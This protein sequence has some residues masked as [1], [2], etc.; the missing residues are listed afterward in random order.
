MFS[1]SRHLK[2]QVEN[3]TDTV[4]SI[5]TSGLRRANELTGGAILPSAAAPVAERP[6]TAEIPPRDMS[7]GS[8]ILSLDGG[9]VRG[10][11]ALILLEAFMLRVKL[12]YGTEEDILPA[13]FFDLIIGTSTG[14]IMALML[15][16]MRMSVADC[17]KA[18]QTLSC[19]IFGGGL[20]TTVL[21]GGL[22]GT[23]RGLGLGMG[24]VKGRE[25]DNFFHMAM[26]SAVMGEPAM[27]DGAKM[28]KHVKRT[29]KDQPHTWDDEEALL[30][31]KDSNN[32]HTAIVT[33]CQA[34][35]VTPH[36]MR[37]Y[38]RRD[39]PTSDKVKIWEAARATSAAPAFFAPIT[40]GDKGVQYV[41]GAVSGHCNPAT[42]AREEA[43]HLWPGRENWLLL[44]LGT[45]APAEV[46]LSGNLPQKLLGFIGLSSNTIQVHEGAARTYHQTYQTGHS[47]YIRLSVEHSIDSVR[48][49]DHE[50]MPQIAAATTTYLSKEV[51]RQMLDHAV[52]LAVGATPILR[53]DLNR[54]TS[55][56]RGPTVAINNQYGII[57]PPQSPPGVQQPFAYPHSSVNPQSMEC[58]PPLYSVP[59][60][61]RKYPGPTNSPV[62]QIQQNM[63]TS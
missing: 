35:A 25:L 27:Y 46:S 53:R 45:G 38:L 1:L 44:S 4:T 39:Q 30:E 21:S 36:L 29:I 34:N 6:N 32:C 52:E 22:L 11:S 19:K 33:A 14:G 51:T 18:Y 7:R 63:P 15:G 43:D 12:H 50:K 61:D 17:I 48:M 10:Y 16:R 58:A 9:G 54:Q 13:D 8:R 62:Q 56:N 31:E 47:P 5:G 57:T 37:S 2:T 40:I 24:V 3:V 60:D 41:D 42:L 49:D 20:A 23:G 55:L 28:E 26:S 59:Y